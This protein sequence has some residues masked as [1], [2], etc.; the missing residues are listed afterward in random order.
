M[1]KEERGIVFTPLLS[2]A[3]NESREM[4]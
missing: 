4:K 1:G 2:L 3:V